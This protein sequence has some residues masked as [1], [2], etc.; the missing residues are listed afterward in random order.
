MTKKKKRRILDTLE[1]LK[2]CDSEDKV[3]DVSHVIVEVDCFHLKVFPIN[4]SM[5]TVSREQFRQRG[6]LRYATWIRITKVTIQV[7]FFI[8]I[9]SARQT[10]NT[11]NFDLTNAYV[12]YRCV[13]TY[14]SLQ[15]ANQS[16]EINRSISEKSNSNRVNLVSRLRNLETVELINLYN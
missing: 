9:F 10:F 4:P 14:E 16:I 1:I 6:L 7:T 12:C 15:K 8:R 11:E 3:C 2:S 13:H 5:L